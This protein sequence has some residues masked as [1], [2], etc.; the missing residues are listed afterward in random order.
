[1]YFAQ[2]KPIL[3]GRGTSTVCAIRKDMRECVTRIKSNRRDIVGV[4]RLSADSG[5]WLR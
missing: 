4:G 3:G 1:M 5:V 2:D